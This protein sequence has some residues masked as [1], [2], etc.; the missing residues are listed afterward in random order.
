MTPSS[1]P[2][3]DPPPC[4]AFVQR[5]DLYLQLSPTS[6]PIRITKDGSST[7]FNGIPDWVY[8]EEVFASDFTFWFSKD[9]HYLL[10][11]SF[12][13][14]KVPVYE[15][16]IYNPNDWKSGETT[17]Y[18][19]NK[20]M[21]YPK[22]GFENPVVSIKVVDVDFLKASSSKGQNEKDVEAS[23]ISLIDPI[24]TRNGASKDDLFD[25]DFE[26]LTDSKKGNGFGKLITEVSWIGKNE[27]LIKEM[28][29][30]SDLMR[31][32]LFDMGKV[33][34]DISKGGEGS[35]NGREAIGEIVRRI[36]ERIRGGWVDSVS[37]WI[38]IALETL[39]VSQLKPSSTR[40]LCLTAPDFVSSSGSNCPTS[41]SESNLYGLLG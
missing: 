37:T 9:G 29:R 23:K 35:E 12:D 7:T 25:Q 13:E 18:L 1:S 41:F 24:I 28:N 33:G 38:G 5:N 8:E 17:P 15:F 10:Y 27:V 2:F 39:L 4:I 31:V 6:K 34:K 20:A 40:T 21:K 11:L 16:P 3:N 32:V 26:S 19:K 36:D 30:E 22:P 14:A